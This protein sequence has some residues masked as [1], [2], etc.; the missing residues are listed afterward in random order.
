MGEDMRAWGVGEVLWDIFPDQERFGGAALN[1]CANLQRLGDHAMLFSAVARDE[2]GVQALRRMEELGLD[3]TYVGVVD[4]PPTGVAVVGTTDAGEPSFVIP[5]PA[6]FDRVSVEALDI[7]GAME[8]SGADSADWLYFGTLM[9]TQAS[10]EEFTIRLARSSA[11]LRCFYDM[12]LRADQW[13]LPLVQRL[14]HLAHV[15]KLNEHEAAIL[16]AQTY[17][18]RP[19]FVLEDFCRYWASEHGIDVICVTLG[20]EGCCVFAEDAIHLVP[21]FSVDVCD[22]V[23]SGDAFAAA[24]LHGYHLGWPFAEIARFANALGALVASRAGATPAWSIEECLALMG[25]SPSDVPRGA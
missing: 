24:F 3:T 1:F 4:A 14:S 18:D 17:P 12:N 13:N 2:R 19:G 9:Q 7:H 22:T 23:G 5:R 10:V 8:D 16:Y 6:A 15:L 11:G 25:S 21:G 20:S